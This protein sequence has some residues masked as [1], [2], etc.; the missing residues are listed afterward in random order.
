MEWGTPVQQGKFLLFCVPQSVKTKETNPTRPGSSTP[1]K[2]AHSFSLL[3]CTTTLRRSLISNIS[4]FIQLTWFFCGVIIS[5]TK[6][7]RLLQEKKV[8]KTNKNENENEITTH[9]IKKFLTVMDKLTFLKQGT[10]GQQTLDYKNLQSS[11][12]CRLQL[13]VSS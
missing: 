1:C 10:L 5:A 12:C 3:F 9:K 7:P 2:E 6:V 8:A 13:P 11:F 4:S